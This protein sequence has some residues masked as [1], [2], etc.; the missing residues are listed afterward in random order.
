[1]PQEVDQ[2]QTRC[3]DSS[4]QVHSI[5]GVGK[6]ITNEFVFN[7]NSIRD[8]LSNSF[9]GELGFK[10]A[11]QETG[12]IIV[13]AFVLRDQLVG[14]RGSGNKPTLLEPEYYEMLQEKKIPRCRQR[15][16]GPSRTF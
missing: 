2:Q 12:E 13:K 6:G 15:Q 11:V 5:K 1:M 16:E 14:K 10:K 8:N 7:A 4:E 9:L 3:N